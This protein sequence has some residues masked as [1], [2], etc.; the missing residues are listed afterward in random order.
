MEERL[1]PSTLNYWQPLNP[2]SDIKW[3]NANNW[4]LGR[5]PIS[6]ATGD[7]AE[8]DSTHTGGNYGCYMDASESCYGIDFEHT[9]A[10]KFELASGCSLTLYSYFDAQGTS[11]PNIY[12]DTAGCSII[13][14]DN[15]SA[16]STFDG[17]KLTGSEATFS[18]LSSGTLEIQNPNYTDWDLLLGSSSHNSGTITIKKAS[19]AFTVGKNRDVKCDVYDLTN[20]IGTGTS[21]SIQNGSG[22]T[23]TYIYVHDDATLQTDTTG[24]S[25]R[26]DIPVYIHGSTGHRGSFIANGELIMLGSNSAS[27]LKDVNG[28]YYHMV[29]DNAS[30]RLT[31]AVSSSSSEGVDFICSVSGGQAGY[32]QTNSALL[33]VVDTGFLDADGTY[34]ANCLVWFDHSTVRVNNS[35]SCVLQLHDLLGTSNQATFKATST[36][37]DFIVATDENSNSRLDLSYFAGTVDTTDTAFITGGNGQSPGTGKPLTFA[38]NMGTSDWTWSTPSGQTWTDVDI[39]GSLA[40]E[41]N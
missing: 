13:T 25:V 24:L 29:N 30:V 34:H 19:S 14:Q 7:E 33:T 27:D 5:V 22:D 6:G 21:T 41:H 12:A 16:A 26:I 8:F 35:A 31:G 9:W 40:Q 20:L 32:L 2:A 15:L 11:T 1:T 18:W 39:G 37:F 3:S 38:N 28:H 36:E 4:S 23:N 17:G 10:N